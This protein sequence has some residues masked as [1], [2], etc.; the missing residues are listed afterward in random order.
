MQYDSVL[1]LLHQ[2]G[3]ISINP[4]NGLLMD[5]YARRNNI[6]PEINS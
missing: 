2:A 5:Y 1:K 3:H 6:V 4:V